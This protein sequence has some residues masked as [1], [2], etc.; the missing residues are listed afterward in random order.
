MTLGFCDSVVRGPCWSHVPL[1]QL[2]TLSG[3]AQKV[4]SSG[5][6]GNILT[7]DL[8]GAL[9]PIPCSHPLSPL[10]CRG[11]PEPGVLLRH[12]PAGA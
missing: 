8:A 5:T 1:L 3:S 12:V 6:K 10:C 4:T 9:L 11:P 7:A 2:I